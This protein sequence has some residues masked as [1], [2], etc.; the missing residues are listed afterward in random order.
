V[1]AHTAIEWAD[2]TWPVTVGCD[3]VSPGC[4]HCYAARLASGRLSGRYP[5]AGLAAGGRFNGTV[6]CLPG[7]LDWPLRW[8]KPRRIFVC[9]TSDLFHPAVPEEFIG[10]VFD[11]MAQTPRHTYQVLTKR[12]GRMRS[13]LLKWEREGW[14]WRRD[15]SLW[16]GPVRGPLPN[17][18]LGVSA[19]D[20]KWWDV[21]W[22]LLA[23]TP[24]AVRFVSAEPL[25]SPID[26]GLA[27]GGLAPDWLIIGGESGRGARPMAM[28]W[29][30]DMLAQ[31]RQ[32]G[33]QTAAADA[34]SGQPAGHRAGRWLVTA[35][36]GR[37]RRTRSAGP[38]RPAPA[39]GGRVVSIARPAPAFIRPP[40][41]R[42]GVLRHD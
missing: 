19:E 25:L 1:S 18:W 41:H 8:R 20:K 31:C 34:I 5:Y 39:P 4:D 27:S 11:V 29:A 22:P 28:E 33:V 40:S 3:H 35:P 6:R 42:P 24:A 14:T 21:R 2:A 9:S 26:M 17:V 16:C 10:S 13:L 30:R 15:D 37:P 23:E 38:A 7:R 12:P 36:A 32:P